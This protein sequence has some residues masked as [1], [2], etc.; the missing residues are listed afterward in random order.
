MFLFFSG[1]RRR[2]NISVKEALEMLLA[3]DNDGNDEF[4]DFDDDIADK[5]YIPNEADMSQSLQDV[6]S[7]ETTQIDEIAQPVSIGSRKRKFDL[8]K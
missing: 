7:L 6:T 1:K 2:K 5:D 4:S 3:S 8:S